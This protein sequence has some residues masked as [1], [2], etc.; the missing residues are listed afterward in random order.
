MYSY[1]SLHMAVQKQDDQHEHSFSSYVRI[2]DIVLRTCLERW[3]IGKSGER[4]SGISVL[5]ARHDDDDDNKPWKTGKWDWKQEVK[6]KLRSKS[7]K[8]SSKKMRCHYYYLRLRCAHSI[9]FLGNAQTETNSLNRRKRSIIKYIWTI[10]NCLPKM[11]KN[12]K[13]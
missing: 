13:S 9:T 5:P 2:R 4:G 3:T 1:G 11:K 10:S 12:W 7:R 6:A 8:L